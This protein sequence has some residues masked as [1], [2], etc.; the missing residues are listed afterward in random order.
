MDMTT[1]RSSRTPAAIALGASLLLAAVAGCERSINTPLANSATQLME[2][3]N[4]IYGM[5]SFLTS[6]GI[7]EGRV[8]A[9]TAFMYADS[10][11][12]DLRKMEIVFYDEVGRERAT[13]TGT[14]GEWSQAS[15]RM[16]ARGDVVLYIHSDSSTI[17]SQEI[18]YDPDQDRI[19]SD[20]AT[21]RT[22]SDGSVTSG[23]SFQ[24]DMSFEN[25]RITDIRGG[26]RRVF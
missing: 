25:I 5:V 13:V 20:S 16:I 10:A 9:D 7:R 3:D 23:T 1:C 8:A 11:K 21:V 4:V 24:S 26:A 18:H 22:L 2:A 14:Y 17:E 15:D 6:R 19:W 12:A